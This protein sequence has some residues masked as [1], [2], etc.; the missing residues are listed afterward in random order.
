MKQRVPESA[1]A[2]GGGQARSCL[3]LSARAVERDGA[4]MGAQI[5]SLPERGVRYGGEWNGQGASRTLPLHH[6]RGGP[7]G[8]AAAL[9]FA[10]FNCEALVI[11]LEDQRARWIERTWNVPGHPEESAVMS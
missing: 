2:V 1:K 6:H 7:A 9:Y 11:S 5:E 10:R 8:L 3:R 4:A